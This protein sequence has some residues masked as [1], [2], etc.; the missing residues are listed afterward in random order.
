MSSAPVVADCTCVALRDE[1]S[2]KLVFVRSL[3]IAVSSKDGD[4]S[5]VLTGRV[6][7]WYNKQQAQEQTLEVA[8]SMSVVLELENNI[9]VV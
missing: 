7:S 3:G 8:S 6:H 5:V 1:I 2:K 9:K 4:V